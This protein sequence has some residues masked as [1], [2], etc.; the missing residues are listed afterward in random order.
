MDHKFANREMRT[1]VIEVYPCLSPKRT[2]SASEI[3]DFSSWSKLRPSLVSTCVRG[4]HGLQCMVLGFV[5]RSGPT[6]VLIGT[7][8]LLWFVW[9]FGTVEQQINK[10]QNTNN[11][12]SLKNIKR[13]RRI[14]DFL[15]FYA[16]NIFAIHPAMQLLSN[17]WPDGFIVSFT[18]RNFFII[19]KVQQSQIK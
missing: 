19:S 14:H 5:V 9:G 3:Q 13:N 8:Q 17:Q 4:K 2:L 10:V 1:C 15:T 6:K 12:Y 7:S 11:L 18:T 16:I